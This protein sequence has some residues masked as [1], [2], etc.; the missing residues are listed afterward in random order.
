MVAPPRPATPYGLGVVLHAPQPYCRGTET[1]NRW[2]GLG[3]RLT[4]KEQEAERDLTAAMT[5]P[6]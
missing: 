6:G 4:Q 5:G 2:A 3:G 1:P